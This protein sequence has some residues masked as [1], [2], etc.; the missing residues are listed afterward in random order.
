M[1]ENDRKL[2]LIL[3]WRS[4]H[5]VPLTTF[6]LWQ[7]HSKQLFAPNFHIRYFTFPP[8]ININDIKKSLFKPHQIPP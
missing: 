5:S 2:A 1:E 8:A 7:K 4:Q 6:E 3:A